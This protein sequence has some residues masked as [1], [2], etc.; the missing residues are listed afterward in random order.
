MI[1]LEA[2]KYYTLTK[3][4]LDIIDPRL[5]QAQLLEEYEQR[6]A[7]KEAQRSIA[8]DIDVP[9]GN[10]RYWEERKNNIPMPE[11]TVSLL[12]SP[13]GQTFLHTIM[14]ALHFV[15][16]EIGGC[17][18][19]LVTL[20]LALSKLQHFIGSSYES[21]RQYAKNMEEKT[22]QFGDHQ[23][24]SLGKGMPK[25]NITMGNDE[26]HHPTPCLVGMDVVSNFILI[27]QYSDKKDAESWNNC[28][29]AAVKNFNVNVFQ[30]TSDQGTGI[31]RHV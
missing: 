25:K 14:V 17:G 11:K 21:Q 6:I 30:V 26:T 8:N 12:E 27:E 29:D 7:N 20:F 13:E 28:F 18:I 2:K 16:V 22:I 5:K 31:L 9:R 23:D 19:R 10:L 15:F 1:T 4:N 3:N 24:E